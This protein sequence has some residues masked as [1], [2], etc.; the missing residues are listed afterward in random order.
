MKTQ[1]EKRKYY[2]LLQVAFIASFLCLPSQTQATNGYWAH[3]HGTKSKSMAGAGTALPL[4]G[5]DAASNPATMVYLGDRF[6]LGAAV[7]YPNRGFKANDDIAPGFGFIPPNDYESKKSAFFV[8]HLSFNKMLGENSSFGISLGGHGGMNTKYNEAIFSVFNN[9][10]G[11]N[12]APVGIDLRQLFLGLTYARKINKRHSFGITPI[13]GAQ[14]VEVKGLEPFRAFSLSPENVTNNG[15]EMSYGGGLR[16]GWYSKL[17]DNLAVGFSYQTQ[18]KMG[19]LDK[20]SGLFAEQGSF[21]VPS[22]VTAGIAYNFTPNITLLIDYQYLGFEEINAISNGSDKIFTPGAIHLGTDDGLGF[23]WENMH[24]GKF[25]VQW[26]VQEDLT[27]RA[28]YSISNQIIPDS[29][30]L[31]NVLAPAVIQEHYTVGFTKSAGNTELNISF[32]YA[33]ENIVSGTN[34]NTG[35]QTGHIRMDQFEFEMSIGFLF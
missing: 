29:Q 13:L 31:F 30:T 24:I 28:G 20:Y 34:P 35:P 9:E 22:N 10:G 25:G 19:D 8:P 32:M 12:T 21:D 2:H 11:I 3:G 16:L 5:M 27:L 17:S 23:G 6:D 7:F 1:G 4:D 18:L 33:P 14:M 26:Q 15:Y